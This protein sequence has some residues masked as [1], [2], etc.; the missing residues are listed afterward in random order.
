MSTDGTNK[1]FYYEDGVPVFD[2]LDEI[3]QGQDA[4]KERENDYKGAQ[5]DLDRSMVRFTGLLVLVTAVTGG[6]SAWQATISRDSANAARDSAVAAARA[7]KIAG[8]TLEEI[9]KGG[10][11]THDFSRGVQSTI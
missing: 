3:K 6:I 2:K 10:T 1:T 7:A 9:K 4:A 8:D 11:D 5:L